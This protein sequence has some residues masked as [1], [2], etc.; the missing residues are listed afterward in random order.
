M[1]KIDI[2]RLKNIPGSE[3]HLVK[4]FEMQ[5]VKTELEEIFFN[6][7]VR[8]DITL[9]NNGDSITLKGSVEGNIRL[10]C[11]R[12]LEYFDMP[13]SEELSEAYYNASKQDTRPDGVNEDWISFR[14]DTLDLT[15]EVIKTI[16]SSL[17][18]KLLCREECRGLCQGCGKNLNVETCDCPKDNTD[19]RLEKLRQLLE[20]E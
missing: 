20:K 10:A 4:E 13:F 7:P 2:S 9:I 14:G 18:M 11:S 12:C 3:E 6:T 17:P 8:L 5:P 15:P 16:T 19:I 1:I